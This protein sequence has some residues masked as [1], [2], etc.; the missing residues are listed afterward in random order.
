MEKLSGK[1]KVFFVSWI[2][3]VVLVFLKET[4]VID[5]PWLWVTAPF[6]GPLAVL[7]ALL[8]VAAVTIALARFFGWIAKH[9]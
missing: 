3:G 2:A 9:L 5:W 8:L 7:Y 6:W 4:N 1:A